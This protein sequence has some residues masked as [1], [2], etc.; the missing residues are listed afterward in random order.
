MPSSVPSRPAGAG[1]WPRDGSPT[2]RSASCGGPLRTSGSRSRCRSAIPRRRW[3]GSPT[4]R[5]WS[6]SGPVVAA[7]SGPAFSGRSASASP[8]ARTAPS[9]SS[10]RPGR[11]PVSAGT[12]SSAWV[13]TAAPRVPSSSASPS[14]RRRGAPSTP[15]TA[16]TVRPT[17]WTRTATNRAS[18]S[19]RRTTGCCPRR[20][21]GTPHG[22]PACRSTGGCPT[23]PR[24]TCSPRCRR[25][26]SP[27]WWAAAVAPGWPACSVR[28]ADTSSSTRTARCWWS[29]GTGLRGAR[30]ASGQPPRHRRSRPGGRTPR[31]DVGRSVGRAMARPSAA[32]D[33]GRGR[34]SPTMRSHR[35]P[36]ARVLAALLTSLVLAS[37]TVGPAGPAAGAGPPAP[38]GAVPAEP[39]W[40]PVVTL[41]R[42][43][44]LGA[45][46]VVVDAAGTTTVAWSRAGSVVATR[47]PA[48]GVF[49]ARTA[50]GPGADAQ[51]GV[52]RNGIVTAIWTRRLPGR[53][54][55]VMTARASASGHW[56]RPAALSPSVADVNGH[57]AHVATLAVSRRGAAVVSW[58]WSEEDSGA[59]QV[60]ARERPAGH[61]WGTAVTLSPVEAAAPVCAIDAS[62]RPVVAYVVNGR[63]FVVRRPASGWTAPRLVGRHGEPPQLAVDDAGDIVVAWSQLQPDGIFRPVA[64]TRPVG[65]RWAAPVTLDPAVGATLTAREPSVVSGPLGRST[66]AWARSDGSL[67][68]SQ[69]P[70]GGS[71]SPPRQVAPAGDPVTGEDPGTRLRV[72]R[73]GAVLLS[74][75]RERPTARYV[76]AAFQPTA[77]PWGA[78]HRVSPLS[79]RAG[80]AD[81]AVQRADRALVVWAGAT[82]PA[83]DVVQLRRLH[84]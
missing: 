36:R 21:A 80:G 75:T 84:P 8:S 67:M 54:P 59:A 5:R 44:D 79:V 24:D 7:R 33:A 14:H 4:S 40:G 47:R 1:G 49:G 55:K 28:S 12:W 71:W 35:Q 69:R 16:V 26:R 61:G 52:D 3:P 43:A 48:G 17:T 18:T 38:A 64:A 23:R 19:C 68:V 10:G 57:G 41:A 42:G 65:G 30:R 70:P 34:G 45:P 62:G 51:L 11:S 22:T 25:A 73:S 82:S 66:A 2:T 60:Q 46:A 77:R 37:V 83:R 74:W 20:S 32:E 76:E 31:R 56:G 72:G 9:P 78:P 15:S 29:A 63:I 81:G 39:H 13:L 58:L 27:S 6:W 50:L 53:G